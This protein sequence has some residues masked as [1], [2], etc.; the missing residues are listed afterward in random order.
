MD[1]AK[2][3]PDYRSRVDCTLGSDLIVV[4]EV[5]SGE[6]WLW[7]GTMSVERDYPLFARLAGRR[8]QDG[9]MALAEPRGTPEGI[10]AQSLFD[11]DQENPYVETWFTLGELL[12]EDWDAYTATWTAVIE[13]MKAWRSAVLTPP[14]REVRVLLWFDS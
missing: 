9:I 14:D 10:T 5:S 12:A 3:H 4:I 11:R 8:P 7:R 13:L 2:G 1:L 6:E